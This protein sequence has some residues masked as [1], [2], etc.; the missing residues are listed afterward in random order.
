M[1]SLLRAALLFVVAAVLPT[2]AMA[3]P[4][5]VS[6]STVAS[7]TLGTTSFSDAT[8]TMQAFF[9]TELTG[10][11]LCIY[12]RLYGFTYVD[13]FAGLTATVTIAGL[14]TYASTGNFF[15]SLMLPGELQLADVEGH[16]GL[17]VESPAFT[18]T[19]FLTP[20]G[21][22]TGPISEPELGANCPPKKFGYCPISMYTS[23]GVL[24]LTSV[25]D[26]ATA[27][28]QVG[29]SVPE[30]GTLGMIVTGLLGVS[31]FLRRSR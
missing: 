30:P 9:T 20:F 21:P 25:A 2:V 6:I 7:G 15:A 3:Y 26:T 27:E 31:G 10:C 28:E 12:D 19:N 22:I 13:G 14:G 11:I 8:V 29:G 24:V 4:I 1:R 5:T 23:G 18:D 17:N 16:L